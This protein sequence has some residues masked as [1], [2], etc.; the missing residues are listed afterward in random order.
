L[1]W[2]LR[3]LCGYDR[4]LCAPVVSAFMRELSR[5]LKRRAKQAFGLAS[6]KDAHTG[7]VC[8]VQR[9]DSALRLNVRLHVLALDGV[10]VRDAVSGSLRFEALAAPSQ[11]DVFEVAPNRRAH[12]EALARERPKSRAPWR[13]ARARALLGRAGPCRLL[14]GRG[15]GHRRERGTGGATRAQTDVW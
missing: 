11:A 12:R 3:A 1:P 15:S 9:T 5:S 10:Y 14:R 4:E 8:A 7:A 13:R 6:V 2:G